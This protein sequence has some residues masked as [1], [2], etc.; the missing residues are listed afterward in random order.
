MIVVTSV[1]PGHTNKEQ[2]HL[3]IESWQSL[4]K[5][6]SIN[7]QEEIKALKSEYKSI[8]FIPTRM[9]IQGLVGK[10]LVSIFSIVEFAIERNESLLIV[11]S[12][13]IV[14]GLPVLKEDGVT[15]FSRYDYSD[16]MDKPV[17]F[18]HGFDMFYI[19]QEF[20]HIYPFSIYA[21]G[22]CYH[23]YVFALVAIENGIPVYYPNGI[24]CYHKTHDVHY[25]LEDYYNLGEH[26]RWHFKLD[27]LLT[28]P[29]VARQSLD[30][31]KANLISY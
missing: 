30:K 9:T 21:M 4:G 31:I 24:Y 16:N 13:I 22:N 2:Q 3:A 18:E 12:D 5:C 11:N 25:P 19:P 26:F 10:P 17:K 28:I 20:L 8:E 7:S 15:L 6:F 23:D 29:Q 1:S 27:K 14:K